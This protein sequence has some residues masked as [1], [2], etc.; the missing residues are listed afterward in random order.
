MKRLSAKQLRDTLGVCAV[1]GYGS[2]GSAL[3]LNLRDSGLQVT[4][5]L[6]S[7]SPSRRK[8]RAERLAVTTI[9]QAVKKSDTVTFALP[10]H[11]H[12]VIYEREVR[13]HLRTGQTLVFLHGTSVA[14]NLI[15]PPAG[16]DVILLA[17]HGPGLAVREQYLSKKHSMSAFTSIHQNASGAAKERLQALALAVG[18]DDPGK[19][20]DTT[21]RDEAVGDL[22]GEQAVLC[23]GLTELIHAGFQ[24]LL[25]AGLSAESAYLEVCYQLDLIINLIKRFGIEGMYQRISVAAQYGSLQTGPKLIDS[26]VKKRMKQALKKIQSGAFARELAVLSDSD[27][28]KLT[29]AMKTMS[30]PEFERAAKKFGE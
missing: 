7:K 19:L 11:T 28:K 21:F 20:I 5:G 3:A 12:R 15:T 16:V 8:A 26:G 29:T 23:G 22:F 30:S 1:L 25:E 27:V 24:T 17:P 14:F 6:A 2:Q 10:D 4:V 9:E 13:D 18:I